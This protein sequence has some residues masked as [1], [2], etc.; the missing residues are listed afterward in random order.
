MVGDPAAVLTC[1]ITFRLIALDS[2]SVTVLFRACSTARQM[3]AKISGNSVAG[4][5]T[6]SPS[7]P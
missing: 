7:A 1:S 6:H 2:G 3:L 4:L 5:L